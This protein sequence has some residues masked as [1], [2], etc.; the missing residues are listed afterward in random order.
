MNIDHLSLLLLLLPASILSFGDVEALPYLEKLKKVDGSL[1]LTK[2]E[3]KATLNPSESLLLHL[4][5]LEFQ[6]YDL[7]GL[8]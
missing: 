7:Q 1:P 3:I 4:E 6:P 8:S 2:E 5:T